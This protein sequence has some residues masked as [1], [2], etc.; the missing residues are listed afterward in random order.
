M[1]IKDIKACLLKSGRRF[2]TLVSFGKIRTI[3]EEEKEEDQD[4]FYTSM[5][6]S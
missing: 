5:H 4:K 6:V 3:Q 2:E 1:E